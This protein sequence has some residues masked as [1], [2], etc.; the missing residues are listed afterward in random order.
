MSFL[1]I[2]INNIKKKLLKID[3]GNV[4]LSLS[5]HLTNADSL[6]DNH[7]F[8]KKAN[9]QDIKI[10]KALDNPEPKISIKKNAFF[11]KYIKSKN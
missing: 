11:A 6:L 9:K 7:A 8:L 2:L 10:K 3:K 5:N 4:N 1:L